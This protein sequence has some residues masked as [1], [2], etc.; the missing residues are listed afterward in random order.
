MIFCLK[1][2]KQTKKLITICFCSCIFSGLDPT[3]GDGSCHS[4]NSESLKHLVIWLKDLTKACQFGSSLLC[5]HRSILLVPV[6][7]PGPSMKMY[8]S[9]LADLFMLQQPRWRPHPYPY[10][11]PSRPFAYPFWGHDHFP[12]YD[13]H[14]LSQSHQGGQKAVRML[15]NMNI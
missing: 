7:A 12:L 15:A 1:K 13:L 5:V 14:S 4:I 9:A 11:E 6:R 3:S 10:S 8:V 2:Q